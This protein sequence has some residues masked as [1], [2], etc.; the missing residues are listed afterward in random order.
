MKQIVDRIVFG[1][2]FFLAALISHVSE[3]LT[4]KYKKTTNKRNAHRVEQTAAARQE[5]ER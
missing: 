2:F 1:V 5:E 3:T 4:G